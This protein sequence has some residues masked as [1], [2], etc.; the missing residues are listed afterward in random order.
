MKENSFLKGIVD[1]LSICFGYLAVAFA[2][3]ISAV[4]N[5]LTPL[6]ATLISMTNL[7]SAGQFAALPIISAG[8]GL[9][10]MALTQL[11]INLRYML[12]SISLTQKFDSSIKF[13][14]RFLIAFGVTD[15]VFGVASSKQKIGK[16]Y[17]YGLILTP[18]LGWSLGTFLG[19]S[20]GNILPTVVTTALSV[21]IYG[22]FVAI[23]FPVAKKETSVAICATIA[24]LLSCAFEFI[25]FL[26]AVPEGFVVIICAV[27]ASA[28]M[29]ALA[30]INQDT[31]VQDV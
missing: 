13:Y 28:V 9:I 18:F 19:A 7:T 6:E 27:V 3:G 1:G 17:M 25:P 31:E 22:M 29:A 30:P 26:S 15:E 2:F 16:K 14:N 21:A 5:G 24:I 20:A 4:G 12:M 23:V 10:E 8:G 11:V